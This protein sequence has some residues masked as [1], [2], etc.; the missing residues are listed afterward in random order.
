MRCHVRNFII[1]ICCMILMILIIYQLMNNSNVSLGSNE[2]DMLISSRIL[3]EELVAQPEPSIPDSNIIFYNG[4]PKCGSISFNKNLRSLSESNGFKFIYQE[5]RGVKLIGNHNKTVQYIDK[6][7]SLSKETRVVK[8]HDVYFLNFNS[9]N[10]SNPNYVNIAREPYSRVA[11]LYYYKQRT[12]KKGSK[13][14]YHLDQIKNLTFEECLYKWQNDI[15]ICGNYFRE[16]MR[17]FCGQHHV[18]LDDKM[19]HI[20][21]QLAKANIARHYKFVG[22]LEEYHVSL[23]ALEKLIPAYFTGASRRRKINE[24]DVKPSFPNK[25]TEKMIKELLKNSC[26]SRI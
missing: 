13:Y 16:V 14:C 21:V 20:G 6:L 23:L 22:L 7:Y 5:G 9:Y 17:V 8:Y 24:P 25:N 3:F 2:E 19:S 1:W 18:C 12:C 11:S 15:Q 26:E 10:Y 4:L